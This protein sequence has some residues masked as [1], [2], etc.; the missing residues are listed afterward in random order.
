MQTV[1]GDATIVVGKAIFR[2]DPDCLGAIRNGRVV[3]LLT[4]VCLTPM[5]KGEGVLGAE[6]DG[7]AVVGNRAVVIL[8]VEGAVAPV[9]EGLDAFCHRLAC[10][11]DDAAAGRAPDFGLVGTG[12]A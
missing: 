11:V 5:R 4:L 6:L 8:T 1:I 2:I 9:L 10:I 12:G 3:V 7:L